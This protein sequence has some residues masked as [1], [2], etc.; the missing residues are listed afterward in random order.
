[1]N[2]DASVQGRFA[3]HGQLININM[4]AITTFYLH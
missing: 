4:Y 1:M 2:T 3:V